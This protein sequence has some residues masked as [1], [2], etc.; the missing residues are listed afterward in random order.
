[1]TVGAELQRRATLK[2]SEE[3]GGVWYNPADSEEA[4]KQWN[5]PAGW[6]RWKGLYNGLQWAVKFIR[7]IHQT[8]KE[9]V[10]QTDR[11]RRDRTSDNMMR[12]VSKSSEKGTMAGKTVIG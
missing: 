9:G 2:E 8:D 4:G 11:D 5:T 7:M 12:S 1:M 6:Q 3:S 10:L